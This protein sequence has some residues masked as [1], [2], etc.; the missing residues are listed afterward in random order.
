MNTPSIGVEEESREDLD[1]PEEE[2]HLGVWRG[3]MDKQTPLKNKNRAR[4]PCACFLEDILQTW[5]DLQSLL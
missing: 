3:Q 4:K 5:D 2:M 1:M